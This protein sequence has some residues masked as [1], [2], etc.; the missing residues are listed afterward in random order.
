[1]RT[2]M[3]GGRSYASSLSYVCLS[4]PQFGVGNVFFLDTYWRFFCSRV[5]NVLRKGV[6]NY[7]DQPAWL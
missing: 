3:T 1:M 4:K 2:K 7:T 6:G 5:Y